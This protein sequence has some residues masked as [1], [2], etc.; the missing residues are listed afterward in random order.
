MNTPKLIKS[1]GVYT[2]EYRSK[3]LYS[4]FNPLKIEKV[5]DN[6]QLKDN[7][8][9]I[10]PSPLLFYGMEKLINKLPNKSKLIFIEV[11]K[12]LY[13]LT[14]NNDNY[15]YI[16]SGFDYLNIIN[17]IDFSS[18]RNCEI[19]PI[20]GGY[21]INKA[22]YDTLLNITLSS[23]HN[24]WQNR[25]TQ[26]NLGE[27]W[28]KNLI[29]NLRTI[30]NHNPLIN[31]QV[32]CPVI[33]A[34]AGESLENSLSFIKNNKENIY[35][36]CVDTALETLL[37]SDIIPDGVLALESQYYN[38]PDFYGA[39]NLNFD[40]IY[41]LTSYPGVLRNLK[42]EKYFTLTKYEDSGFINSLANELGGSTLPPLGSVGISA[43][44]IALQ[45]TK[46]NIY[47]CGLDFSYKIDKTHS[48]GTPYHLSSLINTNRVQSLSNFS[49]SLKRPLIKKRNKLDKIELTDKILYEYALRTKELLG[50]NHRVYDI[51]TKGICVTSNIIDINN[52]QFD[53]CSLKKDSNNSNFEK[54]N[55]YNEITHKIR[56]LICLFDSYFNN[57]VEIDK[58]VSGITKESF[59]F[60]HIAN[61]SNI[62]SS[63]IKR[64]YYSLLRI[65][66]R[67]GL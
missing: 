38:L 47:L 10:F 13:E 65:K 63:N 3:Y 42:G 51:T 1:N 44:F 14:A 29:I 11:D 35:I 46:S 15:F 30:N 9:Y 36:L 64:Y 48:K 67:T 5:I 28:L 66:R 60:S 18:I 4:K 49:S 56:N 24:Y 57:L 31:L 7:T 55:L 6:L 25:I 26:I 39:K 43:L 20:T 2:I 32:N 27:L 16:K 50:D 33:V 34:G 17:S 40:L 62:N 53:I 41:D 61:N 52:L 8:L 21:N 23:L 58:V 12:A 54:N 45:I 59:L 19:I 37:Q 22:L